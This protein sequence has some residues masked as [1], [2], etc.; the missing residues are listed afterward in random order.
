MVK[1][2]QGSVKECMR[3]DIQDRG[4]KRNETEVSVFEI[5]CMGEAR[6]F[7]LQS[8]PFFF[9]FFSVSL[10]LRELKV[11]ESNENCRNVHRKDMFLK[12][13]A[14]A[15]GSPLKQVHKLHAAFGVKEDGLDSHTHTDTQKKKK[16]NTPFKV[17]YCINSED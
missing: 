15:L 1:E 14:S 4:V 13:L 17:L 12:G 10:T 16:K 2:R 11:P 9:F 3:K 7:I 6:L 5:L 8:T